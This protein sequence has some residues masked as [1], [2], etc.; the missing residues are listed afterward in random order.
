MIQRVQSIYLALIF[1]LVAVM[2]FLPLV[3]FQTVDHIFYMNIFRFEGVE[4][5]EF[6]ANLPNIWPIGVLASILA[7][8]SIYSLVNYKNRK[9]QMLVNMFNMLI[10][11][12]LLIAIFLYADNV[13][14]IENVNNEV[15]Y[16][17]AAYFPIATVLLLILANRNIR[18][19][20]KLVKEADRLR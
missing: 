2:S 7:V 3:V 20:E 8:L 6:V 18:K 4:N 16:D 19:D 1:I 5:L 12:A 11:F 13:A 15:I 9:Q 17:V 10:N 14:S